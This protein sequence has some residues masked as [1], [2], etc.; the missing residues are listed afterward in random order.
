MER[1]LTVECTRAGL[2][3]ARGRGRIGGRRRL[4]TDTKVEAAKQLLASGQ[5]PREVASNLGVSMATLYSWVPTAD[6][7]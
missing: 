6:R 3:R 7:R 2:E 4:M 5:P 1:G